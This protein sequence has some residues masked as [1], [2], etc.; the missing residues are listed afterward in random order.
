A[1]LLEERA[2]AGL[3]RAYVERAVQGRTV[4][5]RLDLPAQLRQPAVSKDTLHS[6]YEELSA[7]LTC[8]QLPKATAELVL[9][10]QLLSVSVR[11]ALLYARRA[12]AEI[13][14]PPLDANSFAAVKLTRVTAVY[15]PLLQLCRLLV[16]SFGPGVKGNAHEFPSFLIDMERVFEGYVTQTV[17]A[18]FAGSEC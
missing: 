14:S 3:H 1:H 2:A 6:R 18:A 4:Q 10:S 8:N 15:R 12:F 17:S 11:G 5:G 9:R 16:E 13:S 7:D